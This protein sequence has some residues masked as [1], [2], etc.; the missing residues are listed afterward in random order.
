[1]DPL[2]SRLPIFGLT[3]SK[4]KGSN[5]TLPKASESPEMNSLVKAA[6]VGLDNLPKKKRKNNEINYSKRCTF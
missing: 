6:D 4:L 3:T 2:K 1:M 5:L